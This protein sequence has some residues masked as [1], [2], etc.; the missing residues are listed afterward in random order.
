M[1][2]EY[3]K[4]YEEVATAGLPEWKT[5]NK[6]DLI[7][8]ASY[9]ENG[10]LKDSY[11]AAI[12]LN[13]WNKIGKFYSKCKLVTSPEDIHTWLTISVLYALDHKPWESEKSSIYN[14]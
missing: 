12:M 2:D 11:V 13:Y 8:T 1:L 4:L 14:Y 6:N 10:Y 9:L 3:K 7:K 5:I